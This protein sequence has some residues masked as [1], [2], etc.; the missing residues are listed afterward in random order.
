MLEMRRIL[1]VDP[2]EAVRTGRKLALERLG[3]EVTVA[4]SGDEASELLEGEEDLDFDIVLAE[5]DMACMTGLG[6]LRRIRENDEKY[7][8]L[9]FGLMGT[10]TTSEGQDLAEVCTS[11]HAAFFQKGFLSL[12]EI[13]AV[14][15]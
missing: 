10:R 3:H 9:K 5:N 8:A 13:V 1:V 6:L 4:K 11:L 15:L 14:L 2:N 12:R 7:K